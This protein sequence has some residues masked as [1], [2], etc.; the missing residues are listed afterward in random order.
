M[1]ST[2]APALKKINPVYTA[3][4]DEKPVEITRTLMI[5]PPY[6][7]WDIERFSIDAPSLLKIENSPVT[8][9][10]CAMWYVY[11]VDGKDT[12]ARFRIEFPVSDDSI[13]FSNFGVM[14]QT[15]ELTEEQ[16]KAVKEGKDVVREK[17]GKYELRVN[18]QATPKECKALRDMIDQIYVVAGKH[19]Y[20]Y[21]NSDKGLKVFNSK[22]LLNL[23]R[24]D[25]SV[26]PDNVYESL[27][28][29]IFYPTKN[30]PGLDGIVKR[31]DQ[32]ISGSIGAAVPV[33]GKCPSTFILDDGTKLSLA[34]VTGRGFKHSPEIGMSLFVGAKNKLK[35]TLAN[36][37]VTEWLNSNA[38][39]RRDAID[40]RKNAGVS[41]SEAMK[42][43]SA[44]RDA[45][46][47]TESKD[48]LEKEKAEEAK[49]EAERRRLEEE[50]KLKLESEAQAQAE[51]ELRVELEKER[52]RTERREAAAAK[53]KAEQ[54]A[55]KTVKKPRE[56]TKQDKKKKIKQE[57]PSGSGESVESD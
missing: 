51:E 25:E 14:E 17:T 32:E 34:D 38:V 7:T 18:I 50:E 40:A 33:T 37:I 52:K 45:T 8:L 22:F 1:E 13:S 35:F 3:Y 24:P 5:S 29:P 6:D 55:K 49:A 56:S 20:K 19:L 15:K 53:L 44:L 57:S 47:L 16:K 11:N 46:T 23:E 27:R 26:G 36:T 12:K 43:R 9:Y 42:N 39:G 41:T 10:M 2:N 28:Y 30:V 31:C 54:E 48:N 21:G 4:A